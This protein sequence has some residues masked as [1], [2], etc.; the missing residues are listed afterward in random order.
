MDTKSSFLSNSCFLIFLAILCSLSSFCQKQNNI[1]Y[2]GANAGLDFNSGNP[3][4]LTNGMLNTFEGSACLSDLSGQLLLYTDGVDVY[5]RFHSLMTNG[6]GLH[7]NSTSTHS[8]LI[9]PQP[10]NNQYYYIF[11]VDD[12]AGPDGLKYSIVDLNASSGLGAVIQKNIPICSPTTEKIV[13][14][15]HANDIDVWVI[16]HMW[17]N[18]EFR[19]YLLT[20]TGLN[21]VPVVSNIG[22]PHDGFGI[23]YP[24]NDAIGQ[25]KISPDKTKLALGVGDSRFYEV[26]HFDD[27]TGLLSNPIYIPNPDIISSSRAYGVEFSSNSTLLYTSNTYSTSIYQFDLSNY[28]AAS[29][30]NSKLMVGTIYGQG[31][32]YSAGLM[33]GPDNKIYVA[34]HNYSSVGCIEYPNILGVACNVLN[35]AVSLN[36][37]FCKLGFPTFLTSSI[38]NRKIIVSGCFTGPY[39]FY[40][41]DTTNVISYSWFFNDPGSTNDTSSQSTPVYTFSGPGTYNIQLIISLVDNTSD[42]LFTT[43]IA[44]DPPNLILPDSIGFCPGDSVLLGIATTYHNVSW[45]N[46]STSHSQYLSQPGFFFVSASDSNNCAVSDSILVLSYPKPTVSL[47]NDTLICQGDSIVLSVPSGYANYMWNTG[48]QD[49]LIK[50]GS[51]GQFWVAVMNQFGC[52][53]AD[54]MY[55]DVFIPT[56][57][58]LGYDTILCNGQSLTLNADTAF[59]SYLWNTGDTNSIITVSQSGNYSVLA[60][61]GPNCIS[62]DTILVTFAPVIPIDLGNDTSLCNGDEISLFAGNAYV[63]YLWNNGTTLSS[64]TVGQG[65]T[66]SVTA[67]QADGCTG[68]GSITLLYF[69]WPESLLPD[70]LSACMG[71]PLQLDAGSI[72]E[73]YSYN[74]STGEKTHSITAMSSGTYYV[75]ILNFICMI[76]DSVKIHPCDDIYI[77]NVFTPN[78]DSWNETFHVKGNAVP[79]FKMF[80]YDRWGLLLYQTSDFYAGWDGTYLG[81]PCAD[82]T[83]FFLVLYDKYTNSNEPEKVKASGTV[84]LLR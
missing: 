80:I 64:I 77:P 9:I 26:F 62:T 35:S 32:Y 78:G 11:T 37:R 48:A 43:L 44:T 3:V 66:Y 68:N 70:S 36:N 10:L 59:Y 61:S 51:A 14:V 63:A 4:A 67:T 16:T 82:G 57:L 79:N 50:T 71:L 20:P 17:G 2:F 73:N 31:I 7:G 38:L 40:L 49:S 72:S 6:T 84:T 69:N 23:L 83:Y 8:A 54:S 56:Q 52:S 81:N 34:Q 28:N 21:M 76:T 75:D 29:I 46:G 18:N 47:G 58:F 41:S 65:G 15:K 12:F 39:I 27:A 19:S 74:W 25:I 13:A 24:T 5:N 55:L 60:Y 42:T 53:N 1:W 22:S 30:I 33:R 45:N